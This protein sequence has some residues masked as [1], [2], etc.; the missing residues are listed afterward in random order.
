MP[1]NIKDKETHDLARQLARSTGETL[2]RAV[3][4]A[5]EERLKRVAAALRGGKSRLDRMNEIAAHCASLPVF[6]DRS[7]DDILGYNERGTFD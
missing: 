2:T 1:L 7:P 4:I 5:L 3:K 6:D